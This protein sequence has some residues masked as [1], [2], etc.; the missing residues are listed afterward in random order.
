[1]K[2]KRTILFFTYYGNRYGT[3]HLYRDIQF[4]FTLS[5]S[6]QIYYSIRGS[7]SASKIFSH[8]NNIVSSN[9]T[10]ALRKTNPDLVIYDQ[11]HDFGVLPKFSYPKPLTMLGMDYFFYHDTRFQ[12]IINLVNKYQKGKITIPHV[13]EG[14]EYAII[15]RAIRKLS[16]APVKKSIQS[17]LVTFGG[18]DMSNHTSRVLEALGLLEGSFSIT[19]IFG[20]L[21]RQ[22]RKVESLAHMSPHTITIKYGP[23]ELASFLESADLVIGGS[24]ATLMEALSLGKPCVTIPQSSEEYDFLRDSKLDHCA[25]VMSRTW[26]SKRTARALQDFFTDHPKRRQYA[27]MGKKR[28]DGNGIERIQKI[29]SQLV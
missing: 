28:I 2:K 6:F 21:F 3:G 9:F 14:L 20:P 19:V 1:M 26:S 25:L 10:E 15:R 8:G 23:I 13:Y 4:G 11:P 18:A 5:R 17:L 27:S 24:G 12:T 29:I 22:K 16:P 7:R